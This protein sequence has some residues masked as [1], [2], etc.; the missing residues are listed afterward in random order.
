MAL[1]CGFSRAAFGM[2]LL[3]L[4]RS[5]FFLTFSRNSHIRIN[6]RSEGPFDC[7]E[8]LG[9]ISAARAHLGGSGKKP[10]ATQAVKKS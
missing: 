9:A 1:P 5:Q 3:N 8:A 7:L 6:H 2:S 10:V 4:V